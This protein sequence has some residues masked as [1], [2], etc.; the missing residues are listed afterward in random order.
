MAAEYI[1]FKIMFYFEY[2]SRGGDF[3]FGGLF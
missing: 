3:Y 2:S 1:Y